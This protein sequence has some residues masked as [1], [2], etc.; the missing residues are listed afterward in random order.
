M[1]WCVALWEKRLYYPLAFSLTSLSD[2]PQSITTPASREQEVPSRRD[3]KQRRSRMRKCFTILLMA[4]ISWGARSAFCDVTPPDD[5][6][7]KEVPQPAMNPTHP[8]Y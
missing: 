4:G 3:P 5:A 8:E 7:N 1:N 6:A 2:T